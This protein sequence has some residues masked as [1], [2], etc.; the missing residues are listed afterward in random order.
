M[1]SQIV[2]T[3]VVCRKLELIVSSEEALTR[4]T[5]C[6]LPEARDAQNYY[7]MTEIHDTAPN[8]SLCSVHY[9]LHMRL[10][11]AVSKT[12]GYSLF[13]RNAYSAP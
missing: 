6:C 7:R 9:V 10:L 8:T 2:R 4:L 13:R 1:L 5:R 3:S 12:P 11:Q